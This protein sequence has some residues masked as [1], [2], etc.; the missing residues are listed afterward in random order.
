MSTNI[1]KD[2]VIRL[3][4][5]FTIT[6]IFTIIIIIRIFQLQYIQNEKWIAKTKSIQY[7]MLKTN[8]DRG[9]IYDSNGKIL[10]IS[11]PVYE[12]RLDLVSN[13][14]KDSTFNK[15]VEALADSLSKFP[16]YKSKKEYLNDLKKGR[17]DSIR[18]YLIKEDANYAEHK[19]FK[20][21]PILKLSSFEGGYIYFSR[22]K[23]ILP[24]GILASRT[25][26]YSNYGNDV[27]IE[28]A[29]NNEL[30]SKQPKR[31]HKNISGKW[32]PVF[33]DDYYNSVRGNDV[34]ST[35]DINIQDF[36]HQELLKQCTEFKADTGILVL[37]EVKTGE[38]KAI[39]NLV[40]NKNDTYSEAYN[41]AVGV[42]INP[43]STFKL[44][45][46]I[47]AFEDNH[48]SLNEIVE[49]GSKGY[50]TFY[51]V[52]IKESTR[53][54]YGTLNVKK[55]FEKSSNVGMSMIIN[56]Y[57]K[58]NQTDFVKRLYSMN[59]NDK[60]GL[61][62]KGE[63][64]PIIR[65]PGD[66]L[67]SGVSLPFLSIGYEVELTPLQILSFYNAVANNG[68]MIS[69][70]F[71]KSLKQH[72]KIIK[73]F[74]TRTINSSICSNSTLE[75]AKI[76]LEGVVKNGT[77]S[78]IYD[79]RYRIAGKTGTA[80]VPDRNNGYRSNDNEVKSHYGSF[81][82]YFPADNPVYS[83]IVILKTQ[84][85][86][87]YYGNIVAAPVFKKVADKLYVSSDIWKNKT[88]TSKY[89]ALK[90]APNTKTGNINDIDF[91]LNYLK[92]PV[93]G[94]KDIRS[95]WVITSSINKK[96]EYQN[97]FISKNKIPT[98]VGMGLKDALYI[99]ENL[100]LNVIVKGKGSI[101]EQS[102]EP[103]TEIKKNQRILLSLG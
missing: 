77:A 78:N 52:D 19:R 23:R 17:R 87:R 80:Q 99:L 83:C 28:G 89:N 26:G 103:G 31:L 96:V 66:G 84:D 85:K 45:V 25:I 62:I 75:K 49:T 20:T 36:S 6:A 70:I 92:T 32:V 60:L 21:Y 44:P 67:W 14:L 81:V 13:G 64:P 68:K 27:G 79:I 100:G 55:V 72:G 101:K 15:Y 37:M 97:R 18:H 93:I 90:Y 56:K 61:Q 4:I 30:I 46:L 48:I 57:Y 47:A 59:L 63:K 40:R 58:N 71:V 86:G 16:G 2:I 94:K 10:A 42:P 11:Q 29:F 33:D 1:K 43:G 102:I 38:V 24:N 91:V 3:S 53:H 8:N 35:I 88:K 9:D 39:V 34:V 95:A 98:V 69:P 76:L 54:G 5:I 12:T 7:R 73:E 41:L 50:V 74:K 65:Y 82:G 22:D 51:G